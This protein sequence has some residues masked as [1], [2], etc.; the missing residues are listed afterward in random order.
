MEYPCLSNRQVNPSELLTVYLQSSP[1]KCICMCTQI[2]LMTSAVD[3]RCDLVVSPAEIRSFQSLELLRIMVLKS[4]EH[5]GLLQVTLSVGPARPDG[6][7]SPAAMSIMSGM[8]LLGSL[9]VDGLWDMHYS[10]PS[11]VE[12]PFKLP[13]TA[14][15]GA[16]VE[17][18]CL[19]VS[20]S[21]VNA[22]RLEDKVK[23]VSLTFHGH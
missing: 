22:K 11:K 7:C 10:A 21:V 13:L 9:K 2:G 20:L 16:A 5:M 17:E 23:I 19:Y 15:T 4:Y 12:L 6:T 14:A 1:T 8:T 18:T 3:S